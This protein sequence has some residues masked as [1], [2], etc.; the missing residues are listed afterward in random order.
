V[1]TV[2]ITGGTGLIGQHLCKVLKER[3]YKVALLSRNRL[4]DSDIL[5]YLWDLGK[6]EIDLEAIETSDYII[7]LAGENI[8][9]KRWTAKQRKQI[10]DSRVKTANLIFDKIK[11]NKNVLKAFISASAIGYYGTEPSDKIFNENDPPGN[12]FLGYTCSRWEQ[13]VLKFKELGVRT[14]R[15]RTGIVLTKEGGTLTKMV[16]PVKMGIASPLGSGR[17][18]L[19]WIHIDDLCAIYIKAIEDSI[20]SGAYN[21]V[22]PDHKTNAEFTRTI[23]RVLKK[24][25]WFPNVPGVLL[26]LMYGKMSEIILKGNRVSADKIMASGYKFQFPDLFTALKDLF[27]EN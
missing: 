4:L 21:A 19:P 20:M 1:A 8:G 26:K 22:A 14:V 24:P 13:A 3:G 7:H 23:A 9:E 27:R 16:A 6:K 15:I 18:Y 5:T 11:E 10:I 17:Q 25:R 12:D 2:L